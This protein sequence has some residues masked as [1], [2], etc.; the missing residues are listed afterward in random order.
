M[1][2]K[3]ITVLRSKILIISGG[4]TYLDYKGPFPVEILIL[5]SSKTYVLGAQKSTQNI[6]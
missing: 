5:D 2:K 1:G 3:I 6:F 4:V